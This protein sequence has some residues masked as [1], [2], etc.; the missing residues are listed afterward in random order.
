[1]QATVAVMLL[2]SEP[3][4][5]F[6]L[7]LGFDDTKLCHIVSPTPALT[8][9]TLKTKKILSYEPVSL[10]HFCYFPIHGTPAAMSCPSGQN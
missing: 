1:M 7:A 4:H 3:Y 2:A 5:K 9:S 6:L 8:P 10:L